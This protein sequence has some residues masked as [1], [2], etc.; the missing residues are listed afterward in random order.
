MPIRSGAGTAANCLVVL[1]AVVAEREIVH[2]ALRRRLH[3]KRAEQGIGDALRGFDIAGDHC[4]RV[5]RPQHGI[6]RDN[7][8]DRL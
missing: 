8:L 7:Q 3:A 1:I 2:R 6:G 5:G 4:R